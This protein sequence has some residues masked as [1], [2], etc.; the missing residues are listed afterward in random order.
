[1]KFKFSVRKILREIFDWGINEERICRD[2]RKKISK[3]IDHLKFSEKKEVLRKADQEFLY[4]VLAL[5]EPWKDNY[6]THF[7]RY[8]LSNRL[9]CVD[10]A[11]DVMSKVGQ[12]KQVQQRRNNIK[13]VEKN[14]LELAGDQ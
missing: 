2:Y 4:K 6:T 1:M 8:Y 10:C 7:D 11:L 13:L 3:K 9:N 14:P 12:Q 5:D